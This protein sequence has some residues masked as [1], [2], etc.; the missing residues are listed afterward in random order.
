MS[1]KQRGSGL[2]VIKRDCLL[3]RNCLLGLGRSHLDR[4]RPRRLRK[5]FAIQRA[6]EGKGLSREPYIHKI[7]RK[8]ERR[9]VCFLSVV[10]Q[11][12]FSYEIFSVLT[13]IKV[14]DSCGIATEVAI[15]QGTPP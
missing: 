10:P 5:E 15:F 14:S 8:K 12:V 6:E 4:Q 11:E 13:L 3:R 1:G 9:L 7:H 2:F